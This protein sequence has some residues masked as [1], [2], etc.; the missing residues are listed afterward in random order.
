MREQFR[1]YVVVP[2]FNE[3]AGITAF[4]RE[5]A[6]AMSRLAAEHGGAFTILI[7]D[8]GSLD[9]TGETVERLA[10]EPQPPGVDLRLLS[11]ARNFGHQ[12]ALVAG[13]VEA[14]RDGD[15]AI[16]MD[17]DGEHPIEIVPRLVDCW[18]AGDSIVH[19][20][21]RPNA[22]LTAWKRAT[23]AGYYRTMRTLS[24]LQ[25]APGMADFKLW[26]GDLLRQVRD[27]L[28]G[29]GSTRVFA[30]WLAPGGTVVPYDQRFAR[31]ESRFTSRKMWSLALG[32]LVRYSDVPL[33]L[34]MAVGL[35]SI[36]FAAGLSAF[37]LW[38]S[39]T[40]RTVPGWSSMMIALSIFS[41]LQS[42]S[43]GI[44][45]EYLLRNTFRAA[46]P[47]FVLKR[48]R[49]GAYSRSASDPAR[50]GSAGSA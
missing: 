36:L 39:A 30:A 16:T 44:L 10:R 41:G 8:D 6:S 1:G 50:R 47:K 26:D 9:A 20:A 24:G 48:E 34:S 27:F 42:F 11:L 40:G 46:L 12:A 2:A 32:G 33:R 14:S 18:L 45:G 7:V 38:G 25:I 4:V 43:L 28:P 3:E 35:V 21:R 13:L 37:V 17:A 49:N 23:S 31:R 19:T 15:F 5:L 22:A 29:C